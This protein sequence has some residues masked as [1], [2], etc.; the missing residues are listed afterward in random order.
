MYL[1]SRTGFGLI[2]FADWARELTRGDE[3]F[4]HSNLVFLRRQCRLKFSR[5]IFREEVVPIDPEALK[6]AAQSRDPTALLPNR[7]AAGRNV[8]PELAAI[9]RQRREMREEFMQT[10]ESEFA[11]AGVDVHKLRETLARYRKQSI[12][13]G[14]TLRP[15][16]P[17]S[18]RGEPEAVAAT[19][20]RFSSLRALAGRA[21]PLDQPSSFAFLNEP[22]VFTPIENGAPVLSL[23]SGVGLQSY[24]LAPNNTFFRTLFVADDPSEYA[25]YP[26]WYAWSNDSD[27]AMLVNVS[28]ALELFGNIY[29]EA[30]SASAS[31]WWEAWV[32]CDL[33]GEVA[34]NTSFEGPFEFRTSNFGDVV[35]DDGFFGLGLSQNTTWFEHEDHGMPIDGFLVPANS[36]LLIVVLTGISVSFGGGTHTGAS[37]NNWASADFATDG[38]RVTCP[39]VVVLASP[40]Q[41]T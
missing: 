20:R 34:L 36:M 25:L 21:I 24:S 31:S 39:G 28:T 15:R 4:E 14:A 40:V 2:V 38:Q 3:T 19:S 5:C 26:F 11:K 35:S 12:D 6:R 29:A 18:P 37:S 16:P 41:T 7:I 13:A 17:A 1:F 8:K 23:G 22:F 33:W 30:E 27:S 9:K 10:V 32:E